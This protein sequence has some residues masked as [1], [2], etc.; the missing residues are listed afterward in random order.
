MDGHMMIL[1]KVVNGRVF[2]FT[3]VDGQA[4]ELVTH[5]VSPAEALD[6]GETIFVPLETARMGWIGVLRR[7]I[8]V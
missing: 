4:V 5:V 8:G 6:A 2:M 3:L 7:M 1:R